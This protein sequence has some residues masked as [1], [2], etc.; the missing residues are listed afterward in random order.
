MFLMAANTKTPKTAETNGS[1][2]TKACAVNTR[3]DEATGAWLK[4]LEEDAGIEPVMLIR[5]LVAAAKRFQESN[6]FLAFP[7]QVVDSSQTA[8]RVNLAASALLPEPP[9]SYGSSEQKK[10]KAS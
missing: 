9:A 6:G 5:A 7:L 4:S 1:S 8:P 10:R 3:F 2:G